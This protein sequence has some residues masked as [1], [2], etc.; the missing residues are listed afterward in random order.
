M[1]PLWSSS[2]MACSPPEPPHLAG[3]LGLGGTNSGSRWPTTW[4][5]VFNTVPRDGP[6]L[7][8]GRQGK[9]LCQ[10]PG[11]THRPQMGITGPK[12]TKWGRLG[13]GYL[14]LPV[15]PSPGTLEDF[16]LP[17]CLWAMVT[18]SEKFFLC[19]LDHKNV[20]RTWALNLYSHLAGSF[21]NSWSWAGSLYSSF[22]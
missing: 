16:F 10:E 6:G 11:G 12:C 3:C 7:W 2:G 20:G 5:S 21:Q 18:F 19:K 13:A 15:M 1:G 9:T 8:D 4:P 22:S 17:A 14:M